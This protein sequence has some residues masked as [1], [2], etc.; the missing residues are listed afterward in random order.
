[1]DTALF[2]GSHC[3]AESGHNNCGHFASTWLYKGPD[4]SCHYEP[5]E[6]YGILFSTCILAS[7]FTHG[8]CHWCV[9]EV[10]C[11]ILKRCH[12]TH[13]E[14]LSQAVFPVSLSYSLSLRMGPVKKGCRL[15]LLFPDVKS[16][17]PQQSASRDK[18]FKN[19]HSFLPSYFVL[20][21]RIPLKI[22]TGLVRSEATLFY[23]TSKQTKPQCGH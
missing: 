2:V 6:L 23:C 15:Q 19:V 12:W 11:G 20:L 7:Y 9:C 1:M 10:C 16:G 8:G 4:Q 22:H 3:D 18:Y 14:V 5:F 21:N 17:M 13:L